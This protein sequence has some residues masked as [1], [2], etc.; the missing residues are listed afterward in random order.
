MNFDDEHGAVLGD[1]GVLIHRDGMGTVQI[2]VS[3]PRRLD[4]FDDRNFFDG[5]KDGKRGGSE[6]EQEAGEEH[7]VFSPC[8]IILIISPKSPA[9]PQSPPGNLHSPLSSCHRTQDQDV[10][11]SSKKRPV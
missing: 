7:C 4:L 5:S 10:Q 6:S 8:T 2:S 3:T 11:H 9:L 1:V